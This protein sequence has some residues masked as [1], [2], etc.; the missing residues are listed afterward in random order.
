[1]NRLFLPVAIS[2]LAG[3]GVMESMMTKSIDK[4]AGATVTGV[5]GDLEVRRLGDDGNSFA[6][7]P[8][9]G[10]VLKTA[11]LVLG[12]DAE[13]GSVSVALDGDKASARFDEADWVLR[14]PLG[15]CTDDFVAIVELGNVVISIKDV[16]DRTY[17]FSDTNK[18]SVVAEEG[19][20]GAFIGV[21]DDGLTVIVRTGEVTVTN[22]RSEL[23]IVVHAGEGIRVDGEGKASPHEGKADITWQVS[24][25]TKGIER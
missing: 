6:V 17:T 5:S 21:D 7:A 10:D 1:M 22:E 19:A 15:K 2:T 25:A 18:N 4:T 9:K 3:C 13:G 16:D 20:V 12:S 14:S 11:D 8:K 23:E 24:A